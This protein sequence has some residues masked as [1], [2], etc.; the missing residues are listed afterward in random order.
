MLFGT[1]LRPRLCLRMTAEWE[2]LRASEMA[3]L[4]Q[5]E[6]HVLCNG[7]PHWS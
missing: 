2:R 5:S 1:P 7:D 6:D 3:A 4:L